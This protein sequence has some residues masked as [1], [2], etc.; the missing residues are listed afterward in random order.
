M[1]LWAQDDH[2]GPY[3][4]EA[5]VSESQK[6]MQGWKQNF[7]DVMLLDLKMEKGAMEKGMQTVSRS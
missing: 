7:K 6:E 2:K 1:T 4:R 5:G 3:K